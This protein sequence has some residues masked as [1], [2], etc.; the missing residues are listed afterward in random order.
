MPVMFLTVQEFLLSS[1]VTLVLFL[2]S[3]FGSHVRFGVRLYGQGWQC[4][5]DML[6]PQIHPGPSL[7]IVPWDVTSES[8]F[9]LH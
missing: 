3:R 1:G 4:K 2:K 6:E 8:H 5:A 7:L 9:S